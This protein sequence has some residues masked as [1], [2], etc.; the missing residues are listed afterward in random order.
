AAYSQGLDLKTKG[1]CAGAIQKLR[2][3]ANLGPGYENAQTALGACLLQI[4]LR[5]NE[6]SGDYY[7]GLTWLIRAGDAGWPEAQGALAMSHAF[8]PSAIRNGE[9]AAY[10]MT[11]YQTNPSKLRIGFVPLPAADVAAVEKI[12][13]PAD[14]TAGVA[15]ARAW[16]RHIWLPP[17]PAP[18][19]PETQRGPRRERRGP[20]LG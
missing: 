19:T 4:G 20:P 3:V 14:K 18:G 10:W 12:L 15:R 11:L 7:E 9:E 13:S 17:P 2:P 8:G 5:N 16:K 6:P 1:D